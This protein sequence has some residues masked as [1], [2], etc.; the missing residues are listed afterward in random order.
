[1]HPVI[2]SAG[3]LIGCGHSR[4]CAVIAPEGTVFDQHPA[5]T[6]CGNIM[7]RLLRAEPRRVGREPRQPMTNDEATALLAAALHEIAPEVDLDAVDP[8][9]PFQEVA[10]I[11]SR[12]FLNLVTAIHDRTGIEIPIQDYPKLATL[13]LFVSYLKASGSSASPE[14]SGE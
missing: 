6:N 13:R 7:R 1:M 8:D 3:S 4:Q 9:L 14:V 11:D 5:K 12:D 2:S 10:D